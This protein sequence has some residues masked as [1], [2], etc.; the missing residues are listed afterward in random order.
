MFKLFLL[1]LYAILLLSANRT[2][3]GTVWNHPPGTWAI[4][5]FLSYNITALKK[6]ATISLVHIRKRFCRWQKDEINHSVPSATLSSPAGMIL[7][8]VHYP[9]A[10]YRYPR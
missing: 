5:I 3:E 6:D 7:P 10:S 9:V 4:Y 8:K 1:G 2:V